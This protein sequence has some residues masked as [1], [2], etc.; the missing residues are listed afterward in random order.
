MATQYLTAADTAK[1]VRKALKEAFPDMK[2]SVRS[3]TY[4]GGA[5]LTVAWTDG[6]NIKQVEAVTCRFQGSY[7]D[8]QIDYKGSIYHLVGG[9]PVSFGADS[10]HCRRSFSDAAIEQ[11]IDRIF[12]KYPLNFREAGIAKPTIEEFR[13]GRLW[14]TSIPFLSSHCGDSLQGEI[15]A[16]INHHS[17]RLRGKESPTAQSVFV[18]HDDGYSRQCGSGYSAVSVH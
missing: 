3:H 7:F 4:S 18:T 10:I 9:V 13:S 2:F 17:D 15:N 1:L 12:R 14:A 8:G 5:S 11:G 6:P 16:A